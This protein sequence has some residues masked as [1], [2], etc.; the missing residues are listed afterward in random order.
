MSARQLFRLP[1]RSFCATA[2]G[3]SRP[4]SIARS[5]FTTTRF[6]STTTSALSPSGSGS[7]HQT[8]TSPS[9]IPTPSPPSRTRTASRT[10]STSANSKKTKKSAPKQLKSSSRSAS[11]SQE[12]LGKMISYTT[13]ESYDI[14]TLQSVLW[15]IGQ[16]KDAVNVMGEAVWI[17]GWR[18]GEVWIFESG[19]FVTWGM[20]EKDAFAFVEEVI[21]APYTGDKRIESLPY[22][23]LEVESMDYVV[24]ENERTGLKR[25]LITLGTADPSLDSSTGDIL[26]PLLTSTLSNPPTSSAGLPSSLPS[27]LTRLS[28]SSALVRSTRLGIYE[29][30]LEEFLESVADIPDALIRGSEAPTKKGVLVKRYGRLLKLRQRLELNEE[31]LL[32]SP[33]YFWEYPVLEG[34]YNSLAR[35]LDLKPR[36]SN[37]NI[38]LRHAF[39]EQERLLELLSVRTSHRLEWIIIILILVECILALIRD[40]EFL[41]PE[42][43]DSE[44]GGE[45]PVAAEAQGKWSMEDVDRRLRMLEEKLE[46]GE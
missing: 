31:N 9:P 13:A 33:E 36:M 17:P 30:E 32:D 3:L 11:Q 21:R 44:G 12:G 40:K 35:A 14:S 2:L 42:S 23:E 6:Q 15:R 34:Y 27:L 28:L 46:K 16:G 25:D 22:R 10:P 43:E 8:P 1:A 5:L 4:R 39:E 45:Q 29:E 19:S 7:S 41:W 20:D 24:R 26:T 38:K 37:F 18:N